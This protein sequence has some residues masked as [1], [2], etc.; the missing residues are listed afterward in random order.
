[1]PLGP[2]R[3][4]RLGHAH[5][6]RSAGPR[7]TTRSSPASRSWSRPSPAAPAAPGQSKL[8]DETA[9]VV[10]S[11]LGRTPRL[12]GD[13]GKDHWPVTSALLVGSGVAG[14]RVVG[15]TTDALAGADIDLNT[16]APTKDGKPLLYSSFAAGV[17]ALAGVDASEHIDAEPLH[18][19]SA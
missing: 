11:E 16:G 4:R 14:G 17:L 8:L 18:A 15:A 1:V 5:R 2:A 6:Q 7:C 13:G 9:V 10:V 19:I 3:D 12:N